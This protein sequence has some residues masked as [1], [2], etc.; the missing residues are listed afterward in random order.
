MSTFIFFFFILLFPALV[1]AISE[2]IGQDKYGSI[3]IF[4]LKTVAMYG[5]YLLCVILST[6]IS[7]QLDY[8]IHSNC[9]W[10]GSGEPPCSDFLYKFG[11]MVENYLFSLSLVVAFIFQLV[12]LY[13]LSGKVELAEKSKSI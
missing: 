10:D 4:L 3:P 5:V 2:W 11:N 7:E 13:K 1:T 8:Y 12:A 9:S 6:A